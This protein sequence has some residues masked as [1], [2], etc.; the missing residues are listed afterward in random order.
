VAG[1]RFVVRLDHL[2]LPVETG[3]IY[4]V[5]MGFLD[6]ARKNARKKKE[7]DEARLRELLKQIQDRQNASNM[8]E[9]T[10][11]RLSEEQDR[12][13]E[14]KGRQLSEEFLDEV[15]TR[16]IEPHGTVYEVTTKRERVRHSGSKSWGWSQEEV[17][18]R[19]EA[20]RCFTIANHHIDPTTGQELVEEKKLV[21]T[22]PAIKRWIGR[23]RPETEIYRTSYVQRPLKYHDGL[24]EAVVNFLDRQAR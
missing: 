5:G 10:A 3:A 9:D 19:K 7:E 15:R 1:C 4:D 18:S 8:L 17:I 6:D 21:E 22:L 20:G 16:H 14:E 11:R 2:A 13:S 12:L 24:A 23:D